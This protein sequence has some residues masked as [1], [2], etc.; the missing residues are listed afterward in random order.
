MGQTIAAAN[1]FY[2]GRR[3]YTQKGYLRAVEKYVSPVQDRASLAPGS[4]GSDTA[5]MKNR[6]VVVTGANS[7][8]GKELATY[9]A[10]KG[11]RVYM[12]CRN[13]SRAQAAADEIAATT[14]SDR[15]RVI[16]A[17]VGEPTEV[18]R[19][20]E[21]LSAAEDHVDCLVC[22]AGVLLHTYA[23]NAAG[24]E[25]HFASHLAVGSYALG[26]LLTPLLRKGA[27]PR[28]VLVSS[29]G[30]YGN[31]FPAW[32]VAATAS[33]EA[34]KKYNGVA[35]YSFAKRGQVILAE[36]LAV[37]YP[38]IKWVSCHPGWADTKAVAD[39]FGAGAKLLKPLRTPWE[40]AEGIAWLMQVDGKDLD[41]GAFYLD[42]SVQP[43]HMGGAFM[44]EG[45]ITKSSKEEVDDMMERLKKMCGL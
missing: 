18:R 20:A 25:S 27:D 28:V 38:E 7:G 14:G 36:R 41:A 5:D 13:V 16:I 29:A 22:N 44:T 32:D 15:I 24:V 30:M 42:R 21:E 33:E 35:S 45:T 26:R 9:A 43:K 8:I 10:A 2:H 1:F 19:A 3:N 39:A 17:D 23:E 12:L 37:T 11:A 40:G 34:R 6:V 31:G 4:P